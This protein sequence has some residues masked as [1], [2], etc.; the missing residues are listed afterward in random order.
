MDYGGRDITRCFHWLLA[1]AGFQ[2]REL[3]P[4]NIVDGLLLQE[5]K[6]SYCHLDQVC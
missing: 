5:Y 6:E 2:P 4:R 3:D 1:R